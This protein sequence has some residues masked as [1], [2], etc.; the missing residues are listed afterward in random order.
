MA[1]RLQARGVGGEGGD[2]HAALGL[3]RPARAARVDARLGAGGCVLEHVGGIA[4]QREHALVADLGQRSSVAGRLA[5][6]RRLVDL[7][8]AGVEDMAEGRLDQQAIALGDR[9]RQR[10]IGELERAELETAAALDDV[11]LD[12]TGEPLLLELAGD[13]A[14]GERRCVKR[15]LRSA[16]R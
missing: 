14:G 8:V 7:P 1:D 6:H 10:D 4:D 5:E 13:Q 2:E 16:A 9:V 15:R 11:E 12:L 3:R